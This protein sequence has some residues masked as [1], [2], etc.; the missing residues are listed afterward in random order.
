M[1]PY[2]FQSLDTG[3]L[4][5]IMRRDGGAYVGWS[6]G[7]GKSLAACLL[8]DE[9]D[10][11]RTLVVCPN[12]SKSAVWR[13]EVERFCPWLKVYVLP[14]D[15]AKR[16][17]T[18]REVKA[19]TEPF[20]LIVHYEVLAIIE[21]A[22]TPAALRWSKLGE[23]SLVVADEAHRVK[24]TGA[25]MTRALKKIKTKY[26]LALSGSIIENTVE[27][28]FSPL[29][30]LFPNNYKAKWRDWNDRWLTFVDSG[31]GRV[32]IG[33]Q[34][35]REEA[36]RA[37]L[38]T[39]MCYRTKDDELD[40]PPCTEQTLFVDL[41][42]KQRKAY[43]EVLEQWWTV[44]DD[45]Q[46]IKTDN[47]LAQL[48]KLRQ[49][50]TGLDFGGKLMDS[51]KIDLALDLI[52]DCPEASVAFTWFKQNARSLHARL[53]DR[54]IP[55]FLITGDVPQHRRADYIARFMDGEGRVMVGTLSTMA[56]SV[57]LQRACNMV[58]LDRSWNPAA[59]KQADDRVHR[60]GQ[61]RPVTRTDIVARGTV[62][63]L[64]VLPAL[65]SKEALRRI[66]LGGT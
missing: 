5:D 51:T 12:S 25:K 16:E 57:N 58:R 31:F 32:C 30:W 17:Q 52:A 63:E 4:A 27:E 56:E 53:E 9:L 38:G 55:A 61:T 23:W 15:K 50:A 19:E 46:V 18:L 49:I 10:A 64:R 3:Y 47:V 21:G 8:I 48:T 14:N 66:V 42:P 28:L 35:G 7:M 33:V 22:A 41:S 43:D 2:E 39:F 34:E 11:Q 44:L 13:P 45:G 24:S 6:R 29:N 20:V 65:A 54:G 62:D 26:K 1:K 40:L 37:E 60:I 36:L 59:N